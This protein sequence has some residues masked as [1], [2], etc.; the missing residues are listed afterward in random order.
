MNPPN[1]R[2]IYYGSGHLIP[3]FHGIERTFSWLLS[4]RRTLVSCLRS[5]TKLNDCLTCIF[6]TMTCIFWT[7]IYG[8]VFWDRNQSV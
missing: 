1:G 3:A 5:N 2:S 8:F 6:W 7:A 4:F